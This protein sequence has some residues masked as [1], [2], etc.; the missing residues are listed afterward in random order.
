M[1]VNVAITGVSHP[2]L[3][4]NHPPDIESEIDQAVTIL[5]G[6]KH[7]IGTIQF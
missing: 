4:E 1:I 2:S 3:H 6:K 7:K 5:P